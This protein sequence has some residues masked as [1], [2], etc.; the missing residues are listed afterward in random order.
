[1]NDT[2]SQKLIGKRVRLVRCNDGRTR[3]REGTEGVVTMID[4][5]GTLHVDWDDGTK[6]G[7]VWADGD[8]WAIVS[9]SGG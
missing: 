6:L 1:M 2:P 4:D 8:R 3:L 5:M 9:R 7:L